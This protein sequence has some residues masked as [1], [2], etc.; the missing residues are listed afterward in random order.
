MKILLADD[1]KIERTALRELIGE[2]PNLELIEVEDGQ[3]ALD[4]LCDGLKPDLCI[5]D[6][7]MPKVDGVELLQRMR[8]DPL[9][10]PLKVVMT[11]ATRDRD[12]ILTLAKLQLSGYLLKP[13]DT[14]KSRA[15]LQPLLAAAAAANPQLASRN[16]LAKT[17]LVVDDDEITR[18]TLDSIIRTES[19]WE[20]VTARNGQEALARLHNGLRP[21]VA[22]VDLVMPVLDGLTLVQ[23]VREDPQLKKLKVVVLSGMQDRE[24]IVALAALGVRHYISKP[25]EQTKIISVLKASTTAEEAEAPAEPAKTATP[26]SAPPANQPAQPTS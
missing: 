15:V 26:P 1:D 11:S 14:A 7:R 8:R 16:L 9:L 3:A 13:Y 6:I 5:F 2:Q 10:R 12:T 19:G 23:R 20:V 4:A 17:A 21:D 22:I 25:F 24:K 18:T